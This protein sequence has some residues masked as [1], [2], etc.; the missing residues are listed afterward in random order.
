MQITSINHN[1]ALHGMRGALAVAGCLFGLAAAATAQ[2]NTAT[3][4]MTAQ[5]TMESPTVPGALLR[6]NPLGD[7]VER[8]IAVFLP[9]NYSTL[10]PLPTVYFLPGFGGSSAG[11]ISDPKPWETD[12]QTLA[13]NGHP[14]VLVVVDARTRWACS[15][16]IN[17]RAQGNYGDYIA[18]EIVDFVDSHYRVAPGADNR[19]IAGHS[20]GGFGALRLG[21]AYPKVF[22][23]VV[24]LSPDCDFNLS[25]LPLVTPDVVRNYPLDKIR[26]L[27]PISN[28]DVLYAMAL[29]TAYAPA[30]HSHTGQVDWLYD[31][32]HH[33]REDVWKRW[34]ANDPLQIISQDDN[35]FSQAKSVYLDGAAHDQFKANVG[36][37]G[38]AMLLKARGVNCTFNE[39]PG[40]HSDHVP[41][42]LMAGITWSL[43]KP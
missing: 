21:L 8:K 26:A 13:D 7:P 23:H 20:S 39:P 37:G 36:A 6:G 12:V 1:I 11:A 30:S 38:I 25:H 33:F 10:P 19:I 42:R 41:E 18:H 32:Q 22:G 2:I 16:Y 5:A 15:Q 34:L 24:A 28:S 4:A 14:V 3:P 31:S 27:A 35:A 29:S 43:T 40:G 17:S 9:A